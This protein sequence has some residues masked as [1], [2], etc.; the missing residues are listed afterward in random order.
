M[1]TPDISLIAIYAVSALVWLVLAW[2]LGLYGSGR[3]YSFWL[4]FLLGLAASP[5]VAWIIVALLPEREPKYKVP[6]ELMFAIEEE[7]ARMKA[8][9]TQAAHP[10][11]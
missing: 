1:P 2:A 6:I 8:E 9:G 11:T 5:F 4:C 3:G 7:K 10:G